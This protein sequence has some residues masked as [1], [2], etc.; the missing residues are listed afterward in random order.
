MAHPRETVTKNRDI[1]IIEAERMHGGKRTQSDGWMEV[2][3]VY[4]HT[5]T[6]LLSASYL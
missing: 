3:N 1:F 6:P 5:H 4:I 2:G